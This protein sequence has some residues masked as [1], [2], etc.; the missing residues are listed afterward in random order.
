M[1][2][3]LIY[4][5]FIVYN[6]LRSFVIKQ[7]TILKVAWTGLWE[8]TAVNDAKLL[9]MTSTVSPVVTVVMMSV[10]MFM[11]AKYYYLVFG[12]DVD[13]ILIC[14]YLQIHFV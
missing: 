8:K 5:C 7:E 1:R 13:F 9:R 3:Y 2:W 12:L 14:I 11:D 6:I 10:T 4:I